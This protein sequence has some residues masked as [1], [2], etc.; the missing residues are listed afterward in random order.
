MSSWVIPTGTIPAVLHSELLGGGS[1]KTQVMGLWWRKT[2]QTLLMRTAQMLVT[3]LSSVIQFTEQ[4]WDGLQ[5]DMS[6]YPVSMSRDVRVW[7]QREEEIKHINKKR[8]K[9]NNLVHWR[10][11]FLMSHFQSLNYFGNTFVGFFVTCHIQ[12]NL[13]P[14]QHIILN[15]ESRTYL[16][17]SASKLIK[18]H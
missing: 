18:V 12:K 9:I 2:F 7:S 15:V 8:S 4:N 1:G 13:S 14:W 5:R 10:K 17:I 16:S 11:D 3:S 6:A